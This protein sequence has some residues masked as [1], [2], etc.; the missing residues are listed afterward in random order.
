MMEQLDFSDRV[1]ELP[2]RLDCNYHGWYEWQAYYEDR[3]IVEMLDEQGYI[4]CPLCLAGM[5]GIE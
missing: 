1:I 3:E 2:E 4:D 5:V